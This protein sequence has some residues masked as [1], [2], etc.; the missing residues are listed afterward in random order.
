MATFISE[1]QSLLLAAW[2]AYLMANP[3][4][5]NLAIAEIPPLPADGI[6]SPALRS[7]VVA[8]ESTFPRI[9]LSD[10]NAGLSWSNAGTFYGLL[11]FSATGAQ[12]VYVEPFASPLILLAGDA[13]FIDTDLI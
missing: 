11:L 2:R 8:L 4:R 3:L 13:R 12:L 6:L 5:A 10:P 9:S 7:Q 1:S